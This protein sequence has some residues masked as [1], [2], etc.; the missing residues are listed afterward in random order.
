MEGC[1]LFITASYDPDTLRLLINVFDEAWA[2][3]QKLLG[4]TPLTA[5]AVRAMLAK[6]IMVAAD[7][8]ERDPTRL[9]LIALRAI[10][11]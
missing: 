1:V 3:A 2:A 11:G 4:P 6:R 9:K 10:D 7:N 5:T 8:G